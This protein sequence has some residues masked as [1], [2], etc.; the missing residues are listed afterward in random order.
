MFLI[1]SSNLSLNNSR[2]AMSTSITSN[3]NTSTGKTPKKGV[4][5]R[6]SKKTPLKGSKKSPGNWIKIFTDFYFI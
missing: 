3:S 2:K 5:L 6:N 1:F 4:E